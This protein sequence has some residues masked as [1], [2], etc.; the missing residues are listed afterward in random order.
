MKQFTISIFI[1]ISVLATFITGICRGGANII[2]IVPDGLSPGVWSSVRL[3]AAG[4]DGET[5]LDRMPH[6][7]I[8][9][10]Y[11]ANGWITD[12]AG[13]IS[14]LMTGEKVKIGVLNQDTTAIHREKHGN[15]LE[16]AMEYAHRQGYAC[17]I[18]T[19]TEIYEA[20]PAGGYAHHHKRKNFQEISAQLLD[21]G[22]T[23][24][25]L[26]GAGREYMR[27]AGYFDPEDSSE[28]VR[29]DGR[30]LVEEL[31]GRGYHYVESAE[32]LDDWDIRQQK[33][34]LGLFAYNHLRQEI[35]R[36]DDVFGEPGLWEMT[37]K[38]LSS[39]NAS[40]KPF[41]LLI[42]AG[43]IDHLAHANAHIPLIYEC[44]AFDKTV[45]AAQ[46]FVDEH[47]NTFLIIAEDHPTGG[48]CGIGR[49]VEPDIVKTYLWPGPF[50]EFDEEG[51]PVNSKTLQTIRFGWASSPFT[52]INRERK[53]GG[54]YAKGHHTAE[55]CI[56]YADGWGSHFVNGYL[57]NTDV[58][59]M[60]RLALPP[61]E[62]KS[63]TSV[64]LTGGL[65]DV[66]KTKRRMVEFKLKLEHDAEIRIEVY[67]MQGNLMM[68]QTVRTMAG[69]L[70]TIMWK[71]KK[72][73]LPALFKYRW[74]VEGE[75]E[76]KG[77]FGLHR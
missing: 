36:D 65:T 63:G 20:T 19:T 33:K 35:Y 71:A 1:L 30:D 75:F 60:L 41:F 51:F 76:G 40:G 11:A 18:I 14:A 12:S 73:Q 74:Y 32:E 23:P 2:F 48:G 49:E 24:E 17:G 13:G 62:P 77:T 47:P 42:E 37:E 28:C 70:T 34:L 9:T 52:H 55:D 4:H 5:N 3:V 54:S 53:P 16:T 46:K 7:A 15:N 10:T 25:I 44:I 68:K 67:D 59:Q 57:N 26:M 27:P 21:G 45:G 50:G 8:Y 66:V 39:L 31:T 6:T 61:E 58:Y 72:R 43:A 64:H 56:L 29:T 22:F 69:A 38:A